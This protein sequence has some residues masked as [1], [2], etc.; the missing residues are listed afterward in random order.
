MQPTKQDEE[1][2]IGYLSSETQYRDFLE[3]TAIQTLWFE[4]SDFFS[5]EPR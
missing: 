2:S 4:I 1:E 3:E 5:T